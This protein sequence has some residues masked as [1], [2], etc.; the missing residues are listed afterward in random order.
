VP[1][2]Q[3]YGPGSRDGVVLSPLLTRDAVLQ[4]LS[5]AKGNSQ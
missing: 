5:A 3:I 2:N 4:T 1:F